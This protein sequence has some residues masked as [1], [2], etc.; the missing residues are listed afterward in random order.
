MRRGVCQLIDHAEPDQV[1][2]KRGKSATPLRLGVHLG[3]PGF[4]GTREATLV[5]GVTGRDGHAQV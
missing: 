4:D 5:G 1:L 2:P 3:N